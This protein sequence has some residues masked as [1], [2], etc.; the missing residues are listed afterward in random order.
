MKPP[1]H[2]SEQ[3]MKTNVPIQKQR[4][5]TKTQPPDIQRRINAGW[6]RLWRAVYPDT[7]PPTKVQS[8]TSGGS[9]PCHRLARFGSGDT[10][11]DR[12]DTF[13]GPIQGDMKA[14]SKAQSLGEEGRHPRFRVSRSATQRPAAADY[15][16]RFLCAGFA[17]ALFVS[18]CASPRPLKGGRAVTT[19][20]PT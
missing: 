7:P 1:A 12:S 9:A 16:S 15:L 20:N 4:I 13:C 2:E 19:R 3:R 17:L 8:P 5:E 6:L 11:S 18:G 10:A 14:K